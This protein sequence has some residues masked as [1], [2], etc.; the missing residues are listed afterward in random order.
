LTHGAKISFA[1]NGKSTPVSLVGVP[2]APVNGQVPLEAALPDGFPGGYGTVGTVT[3]TQVLATGTLIPIPAIQTL[4]NTTYVFAV[5]KDNKVSQINIAVQADSGILAAVTGL[6]D[7]AQ[8]VLN[9]PPGLLPGATVRLVKPE[10]LKTTA[11]TTKKPAGPDGK[12][13]Q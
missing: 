4:E 10:V 13:A 9:P 11:D 7:G 2:S 12:G 6:D 5:G 1:L 8:V 3:Y